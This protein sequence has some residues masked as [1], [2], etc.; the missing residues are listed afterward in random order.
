MTEILTLQ[1]EES[2]ISRE[3]LSI[4]QRDETRTLD[5]QPVSKIW[6]CGMGSCY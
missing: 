4:M 2:A 6:I 3:K 1:R 5:V